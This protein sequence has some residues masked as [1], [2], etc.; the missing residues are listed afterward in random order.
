MLAKDWPGLLIRRDAAREYPHGRAASD[1]IGY[2]GAI[3]KSEYE[4]II[5]EMQ[6]LKAYLEEEEKGLEAPLPEGYASIAEVKKRFKDLEWLAYTVYDYVGKTGIEGRFEEELRGFQG[7]KTY[8]SDSHGHL[9]KELPGT[10][11]AVSGKRLLLTI[12]SELQEFAEKMLAISEETRETRVKYEDKGTIKA[13]KVPW[14]KGGAIVVM[15]PHTGEV[16]TLASYPRLDPNDFIRSSNEEKMKEKKLKVR[17]WL[18]GEGAAADIWNGK[19]ALKRER[20]DKDKDQFYDEE[21]KLTWDHFLDLILAKDSPVKAVLSEI[22]T[23]QTALKY[24][25]NPH[26]TTHEQNLVKDILG[27]LVSEVPEPFLKLKLADH[28]QL[29]QA[30]VEVKDATQ[31]IVRKLFSETDFKTW[32]VTEEKG[33]I[34][35]KREEEKALKKYPKPYID[36]L[37]EEEKKQ[38]TAFFNRHKAELMLSFLKGTLTGAPYSQELKSWHDEIKKGAHAHLKWVKNYQFLLTTLEKYDG[39]AILQYLSTLKSFSEL[40]QPL[41][42]NYRQ[43]KRIKKPHLQKHL[44][45]SFY[46]A[47]GYGYGRS[48]AFRQAATQG[49]I[50]K[51]ITAYTALKQEYSKKGGA[52][53]LNPLTIDEQYFKSGSQVYLGYTEGGKPIPQLYNGGRLPK[54]V[55]SNVGKLDILKALEYSSNPYFAILASD[56]IEKPD[57][58][59]QSAKQFSYGAKT[60]I[61]LP[62]EI[63]GSLPKDL[64]TNKNGLYATAIGQHNLVVTPLQTAVFLSSLANKGSV[65]KPQVISL[66]AGKVPNRGFEE[67]PQMEDYPFKDPLKAVGIDFPLFTYL[68]PKEE[69][70]LIH[71]TEKETIRTVLMPDPIQRMLLEGMRLVVQKTYEGSLF[72]LSKLYHDYPELMSDF[73]DLKAHIIGKTSTSEAIE[74]LNLDKPDENPLFTH[75]WFGGISFEQEV[76]ENRFPKPELVIVIYLRYGGYGKEAAPLAT[77]IVKKWREIKAKYKS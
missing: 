15:D 3:S 26:L 29:M 47:Y 19:T 21:K 36:Y 75:V 40:N 68:T 54:S 57:D 5:H 14:I 70:N 48:Q 33:F 41:I 60:G 55:H 16:L 58:L 9:L 59:L 17:S 64:D 72:Q 25:S 23:L 73:I 31:E 34:Q 12:S 65:L 46:P 67:I 35:A 38:F 53:K 27:L 52:R 51:L 61:D 43:L 42:G 50:F 8:F 11:E 49:S 74:R 28:F 7:K 76:R 77:Q 44:A 37:D 10:R 24:T 30:W 4:A 22:K 66:K 62:A 18:E 56:I 2:L 20:Y 45:A 63:A 32:R 13:D 39:A 1:V 71:K 69:A 6:G